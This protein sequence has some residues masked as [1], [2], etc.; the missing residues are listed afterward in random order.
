MKLSKKL[1]IPLIIKVT[2]TNTDDTELLCYIEPAVSSPYMVLNLKDKV[3][4]DLTLRV[5]REV[6]ITFGS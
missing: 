5:K 3:F 1:W 4:V 2:I 6:M